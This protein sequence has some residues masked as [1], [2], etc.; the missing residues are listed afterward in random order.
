MKS[1]PA[2]THSIRTPKGLD[3]FAIV[4][5]GV[6]LLHCLLVPLALFLG[7]LL[8][9]WLSD[10]ETTVHWVLLAFAVPSSAIALGRGYV[11]HRNKT[12]VILGAAGLVGM[13]FGVSHLWGP[14]HE[15][16]LTTAGV[17][18]LLIAHTRN[19]LLLARHEHDDHD[20]AH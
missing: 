1:N 12:I 10:S 6:C 20:H 2:V 15:V 7:P 9:G 3:R 11:K 17:T 8:G 19:V 5:S 16:I 18:L 13:F 14:T 4:L